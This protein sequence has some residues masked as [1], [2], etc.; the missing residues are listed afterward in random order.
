MSRL[1]SH[2]KKQ[3]FQK[4]IFFLICI[5]LLIGLLFFMG[6]KALINSSLFIG[7]LFSNKSDQSPE[8]QDNFFGTLYIDS[9]PTATNSARIVVSGSASNFKTIEYY[10]ND[11]KVDSRTVSDVPSFSDEIGN[12]KKGVNN[13][14]IKAIAEDTDKEKKSQV[15]NVFY[16]DDK[17]KLEITEPQDNSKTSKSEI[18]VVGTTD[19]DISVK[20]NQ[21]PVIVDASGK[22]QSSIRLKEGENKIEI[23]AIDD[24]GNIETKTITV[25][26][27]K[28]D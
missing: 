3:F 10:I 28:D 5:V 24:A 1:E 27:Q 14:Y 4:M 9:I 7:G 26:Y 20:V 8:T 13:V 16:N 18:T 19:K 21:F 2:R 15:Y 12:L 17:P 23:T 22:F 11:E 25:T 6:F